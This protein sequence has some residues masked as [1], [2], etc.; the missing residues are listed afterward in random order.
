VGE[1]I[2]DEFAGFGPARPTSVAAGLCVGDPAIG[3]A[4]RRLGQPGLRSSS[5]PAGISHRR[6][7]MAVL[8]E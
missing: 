6:R 8:F 4:H 7:A 3:M 5:L 1:F 2:G